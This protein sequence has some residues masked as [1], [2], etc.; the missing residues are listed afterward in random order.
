MKHKLPKIRKVLDQKQ[1]HLCLEE[2]YNLLSVE[3]L[4]IS[5][6]WLFNSYSIFKDHEKY[7]ILIFLVKKTFDFYVTNFI[8]L[9]W[10]EFSNLKKIELGKYSIINVAKELNISK[11]TTRRKIEELEKENIIK[12]TKNGI[13]VQP[14]FYSSKFIKDHEIFRKSI[15][16]VISN[17]SKILV[18]EEI[19]KEKIK[20]ES[21]ERVIHQNFSYA[22][23][24][25]FELMLPLLVDF[26]T[27]FKDLES[28]HVW[29]IC[30]LNQNYEV[31]RYLKLNN[32]NIKNRKDFFEIHTK[33]LNKV[34]I[35]AMSI[36]NISEIPRAT[37]IRK[38]NAM[39]KKKS[40]Y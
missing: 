40:I 36:S 23:K 30:T 26:K 35:N 2:N 11:E 33:L 25:F 15:C 3:W 34:G 9:N 24:V 10:N 4:K 8:K 31:Q 17:F 6:K 19:I 20:R 5:S 39:L 38:L 1:I 29:M 13:T 18:E 21:V 37:V 16:V 32:L 28:C 12:K 14:E 7:L 27:I 22:W